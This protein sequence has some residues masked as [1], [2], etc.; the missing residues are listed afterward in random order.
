MLKNNKAASAPG[1][2]SSEGRVGGDE[3]DRA[4]ALQVTARTL[5]FPLRWG[6]MGG[7]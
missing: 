6:A 5:A 7:D 4:E 1:M 3:V 2:G